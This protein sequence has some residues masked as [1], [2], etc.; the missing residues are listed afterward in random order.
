MLL[1]LLARASVGVRAALS[2]A[3]AALT[4]A[5]LPPGLWRPQLRRLGGLAALIF[6]LTAIGAGA[7]GRSGVAGRQALSDTTNKERSCHPH[8][9]FVAA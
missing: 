9:L 3:L 7:L 4:A 8:S 6:V 1:L 5:A 2:G